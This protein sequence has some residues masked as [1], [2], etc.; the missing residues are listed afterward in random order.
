MKICFPVERP[1]GLGS[2]VYGHFGS[3]PAFVVVDTDTAEVSAVVNR[4]LQHEH[5]RC[6]P[7]K[8]LDGHAVDAVVV[9][10]IGKG[11]LAGL[12]RAGIR[13][14]AA[15]PGTVAENLEHWKAGRLPEWDPARTCGGHGHGG[16][17]G[18]HG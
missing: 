6:S 18:H 12:S 8:A 14:F 3:A 1:D 17:C 7:L 2:T 9:G 15:F 4:D 11:A 10:G 5:G 13:V 16:G